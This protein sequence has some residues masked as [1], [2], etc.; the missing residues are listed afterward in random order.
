MIKQKTPT[1]LSSS[2]KKLGF[3]KVLEVSGRGRNIYCSIVAD[4]SGIL[5]SIHL[6]NGNLL[7][8]RSNRAS[9]KRIG[10]YNIVYGTNSTPSAPGVRS[11]DFVCFSTS[12]AAAGPHCRLRPSRA[13]GAAP[14][15]TL[16]IFE[17]F[18]PFFL[19]RGGRVAPRIECVNVR[20]ISYAGGPPLGRA[21][22]PKSRSAC[23]FEA[24]LSLAQQM[25]SRG[26]RRRPREERVLMR[27][28]SGDL[29]RK[30]VGSPPAQSAQL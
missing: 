8:K 9:T 25:L 27:S 5:R 15:S 19:S 6:S 3:G 16:R 26:R 20:T 4:R 23:K 21:P 12:K 7:L 10:T 1:I 30:A 29:C 28:N 11:Y 17:Q 18:A 24:A 2:K 14:V 13:A 22:E